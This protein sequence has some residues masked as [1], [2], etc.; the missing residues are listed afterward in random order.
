LVRQL[1]VESLLLGFGGCL[2]GC[3]LAYVG[4]QLVTLVPG[5][6]VPGEADMS[7]NLPVLVFAVTVSLMTTL[8]FGLSPAM[9]A[10]KRNIHSNLQSSGVNVNASRTGVRVRAGLVTGQVALSIL[11][12]VFAGLMIRSFLAVTSFDPGIK[13]QGLLVALLHFSGR[14]YETVPAKRAFFEQAFDRASTLPGVT[15]VAV[16][17]G[18]PLMGIPIS[19]DVTIPGE[20]HDKPWRTGVDAVSKRYF[21]TL[22]LQLLHG[23]L[24]SS[25]DIGAARRVAVI[26]SALANNYFR[27]EDALGKEIKFNIFDELPDAPRNAYFQI[28]GIVSNLK[29]FRPNEPVLAQAYIPYTFAS[30]GDRDLL[31]RSVTNPLLIV[32]PLRQVLTDLDPNVVLM[33]PE[34]L[35][36]A[37]QQYVYSKPEFRLISFSTCAG[38]GLALAL[39]GLFGVMSY[40]V[41][42]QTHEIGVRMALGAQPG[43]VLLLVLRKGLT[44]VG[45][46]IGFGLLVSFLSVRILRSQ[47][48]GVSAFDPW[49][50][51]LAPAAFISVALLACNFPAR[52]ATRVDP[53]IALRYE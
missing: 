51:L 1:L 44:L 32:N 45:S 15:N 28:V 12:L 35:D 16:S 3:S 9:I 6:G 13:T 8:L 53:I 47:L 10:I 30:F 19:D 7:L 38:I 17:F 37:L 25:A 29:N 11:L 27:G 43:D 46:G 24:L 14:Q 20:P 34:T 40:S 42:L 23:R 2:A 52:R 22:G 39:I 26:N 31:V 49:T 50:L 33:K 4:L 48:W 41:T 36:A 21:A 5:I 18:F